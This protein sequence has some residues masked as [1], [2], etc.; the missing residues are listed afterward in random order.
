M[1]KDVKDILTKRA[2]EFLD[3]VL[4][5]LLEGGIPFAEKSS[6]IA[7]LQGALYE[8]LESSEIDNGIPFSGQAVKNEEKGKQVA[9]KKAL[10]RKIKRFIEERKLSYVKAG[11][12][13]GV[14]SGPL[15]NWLNEKT[16]PSR[17]S[18]LKIKEV[19]K[20]FNTSKI[21]EGPG[22]NKDSKEIPF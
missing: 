14:S 9:E 19:L 17:T 18:L 10:I 12:M 6:V 15:Y 7:R 21:E 1:N 11:K 3:S 20:K 4:S 8:L 13:L 5:D 16:L 22:N 2:S